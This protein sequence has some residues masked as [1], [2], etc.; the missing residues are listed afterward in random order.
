MTP[1]FLNTL[2][3]TAGIQYASHIFS[4]R[5]SRRM[6]PKPCREACRVDA[7]LASASS[8][9]QDAEK[10]VE[11]KSE[12]NIV[13]KVAVSFVIGAIGSAVG[14]LIGA[15]GGVAMTPLLTFLVGLSQHQAHGTALCVVSVTA[16]VGAL[17]Y[18][19]AKQLALPAAAFLAS[20]ALITSPLGARAASRLPAKRLQF[21]F[22]LFLIIVS[23]LIPIMPRV[24]IS[25]P[26][27]LLSV[28]KQRVVM[29]AV[30]SLTGF[31]SGLLGIGGGTVMVPALVLLAAQ[32]QKLAQGTALCAMIIPSLLGSLTHFRLGNVVLPI[33]PGLALGAILGG[34]AGSGLALHL[35]ERALRLV[36]CSIFLLIGGRYVLQN[37]G[38]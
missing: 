34:L 1:A 8:S 7:P 13:S 21:Y 36:C 14:S 25:T 35:Q 9:S 15:G 32:S 23:F 38:Q 18:N 29:M 5:K 27:L 22:G 28:K 10:T 24:L 30:G 37:V 19:A 12:S 4:V 2:P 3:L 11:Q 20:T 31:L 33:L 6:V 26:G 17:R 16:A